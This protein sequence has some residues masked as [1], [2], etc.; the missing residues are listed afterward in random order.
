MRTR[1]ADAIRPSEKKNNV[2]NSR[3]KIPAVSSPVQFSVSATLKAG[4]LA[5]PRRLYN[6]PHQSAINISSRYLQ[7]RHMQQE[8]MEHMQ[9]KTNKNS[10]QQVLEPNNAAAVFVDT[11][12]LSTPPS[13]WGITIHQFICGL[14]SN[15]FKQSRIS[16]GKQFTSVDVWKAIKKWFIFFS[17]CTLESRKFLSSLVFTTAW[18]FFWQIFHS[19]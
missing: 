14:V 11:C 1:Q 12:V 18:H 2:Q 10:D 6:T 13:V 16:P 17:I 19:Y 9:V 5:H 3:C 15:R 7:Y 4:W 8:D